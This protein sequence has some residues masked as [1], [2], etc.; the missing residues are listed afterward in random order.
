M[1]TFDPHFGN[2]YKGHMGLNP[3]N[4]KEIEAGLASAIKNLN[5]PQGI[6][7]AQKAK[8]SALINWG[9]VVIVLFMA[10]CAFMAGL[11]LGIDGGK[12]IGIRQIQDEAAV[13]GFAAYETNAGI[14]RF[15]WSVRDKSPL[16]I[17]GGMKSVSDSSQERVL[18]LVDTNTAHATN[19]WAG[20]VWPG[21]V[22][23]PGSE[24]DAHYGINGRFRAVGTNFTYGFHAI[25]WR[26]EVE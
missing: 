1:N 14:E 11:C 6:E 16:R 18:W 17:N 4:R 23:W 15:V 9:E 2:D 22:L 26:Y 13:L 24:I 7:V 8:K 20:H 12:K 19:A 25:R 3:N 5:P 10:L 21:V